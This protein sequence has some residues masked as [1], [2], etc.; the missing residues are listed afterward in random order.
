MGPMFDR[1]PR[2][3]TRSPCTCGCDRLDGRHD[4]STERAVQARTTGRGGPDDQS[5]SHDRLDRRRARI[6]SRRRPGATSDGHGGRLGSASDTVGRTRSAGHLGLPEPDSP[7]ASAVSSPIERSSRRKKPR[8]SSAR[9]SSVTVSIGVTAGGAR[10][11]PRLRRNLVH[12]QPRAEHPDVTGGGSAGWS[13]STPDPGS[14]E[15]RGGES[16]AWPREPARF[17]QL[18]DGSPHV[19]ALHLT[20]DATS[21]PGL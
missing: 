16:G 19:C 1:N 21:A 9:R 4:P 12:P 3:C 15:A 7:S 11:C 2:Q 10:P 5:R 13:S 17:P 20:D 8:K 6:V 14:R 18:M